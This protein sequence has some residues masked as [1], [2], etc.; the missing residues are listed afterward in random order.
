M[1]DPVHDRRAPIS[2]QLAVRVAALGGLAFVLFA[3]IFFRLWFLQVLSGDRYVAQATQNRVRQQPVQAPRGDIVD[4]KGNT[5]VENRAAIVLQLD[6]KE[7]PDEELLLAAKWGDAAA[8]RKLR[9]EG[10]Q[11]PPVAIPAVPPSLRT[12][13]ARLRKVT[14]LT[15]AQIQERVVVGLYQTPFAPVKLKTDVKPA[16]QQ[17][18]EEHL[19]RFPGLDAP[20][21]FVRRYPHGQLAAQVFGTIGQL[22]KQQ[23]GTKRYRGIRSGS[24]VGKGG[25]ERTYDQYLRGLDGVEKF[26]VDAGGRQVGQTQARRGRVGRTLATSLDL[27]LQKVG[28]QALARAGGGVKPGA[29]VAMDPYTGE[30]KAMGS[31][32]SFDPNEFSR[33]L[34]QKR[35]DELN[36]GAGAPLT[37]RAVS[38]EYPTGSTFKIVT[39]LAGLSKGL[40]SPDRVID[41]PGRINLFPDDPNGYRQNAKAQ[42]NGP[43]DLRKALQVSSDVYFYLLGKQLFERGGR[44]LQDWAHK[45]GFGRLTGIDT[46]AETKGVVPS[47]AQRHAF[48]R[49]LNKAERACRAKRRVPSCGYSDL[50]DKGFLAGDEVNLAI[51]QGDLQAT[52]L[53]VALAYSAIATGGRIPTPHLG[54]EIQDDQGRVVSPLP[55]SSSRTVKLPA[56][57]LQAIRDGLH[58]ATSAPKG[59]SVDVFKGWDQ[60]RFPVYGKTG[61]AS[62][63][64][65]KPDQSWYAAYVPRTATNRKPLLVVVT[66]EGGG[67]GAEAAAPAARQL[68]SQWFTGKPGAFTAGSSSTR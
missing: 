65:P 48:N 3:V 19:K 1:I 37:N 33:P 26:Y 68:F 60:N 61:T 18:V 46:G 53:Q 58:L 12:R 9:P 67:F 10:K 56:V 45:L 30:V 36:N 28:Q 2:P 7:I 54:V 8:K 27:D 62:F 38:S 59:T 25:L 16:V 47:N 39:A 15:S 21:L 23:V 44:S 11:G 57:G 49:A 31:V 20:T 24:I 42:A 6:P 35:S 32:P 64:P 29:F 50:T 17:Y 13:F 66:V 43:V 40:I 63:A 5:L 34:T 52:P 51:G 14:G 4:A 22:T 55:K 41:D